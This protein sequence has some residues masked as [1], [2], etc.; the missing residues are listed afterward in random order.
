MKTRAYRF[1]FEQGQDVMLPWNMYNV[2]NEDIE[3]KIPQLSQLA[4]DDSE[5]VDSIFSE[6][7][8]HEA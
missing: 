8:H 6:N 3:P 7:E 2:I 1:R 4:Y 5:E